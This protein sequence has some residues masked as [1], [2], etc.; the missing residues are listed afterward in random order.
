MSRVNEVGLMKIS[1]V[2]PVFNRVEGLP[3]L[4]STL[5]AALD[6]LPQDADGQNEPS[7]AVV[8]ATARG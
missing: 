8:G 5:C 1:V 4:Y 3:A 2:T 6:T 7:K